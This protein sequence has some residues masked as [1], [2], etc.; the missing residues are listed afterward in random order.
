MRQRCHSGKGDAFTLIELL[1]VIAIIAVLAALLLPSLNR[2]KASA[3]AAAC[4]NNVRQLGLAL[5]MYVSDTGTFPPVA[6]QTA[7][8][9]SP[10][11]WYDFLLPS[12]I[13]RQLLLCPGT[14]HT[15]NTPPNEDWS[16]VDYGYNSEGTHRRLSSDPPLGL[17]EWQ[18][19]PIP[20]SRVLVPSDMLA[21]GEIWEFGQD[22]LFRSSVSVFPAAEYRHGKAFN[23]VFC[24]GHV[25]HSNPSSFPIVHFR[26]GFWWGFEP[27]EGRYKRFNN[28]N[29]P[30]PETWP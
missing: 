4:V 12:N 28:D 15:V 6:S 27:D 24:D 14:G 19:D 16:G 1:M 22:I 10:P 30:H 11:F 13:T 7:N 2:A 21:I 9:E 25:E 18:S 3:K 26:G 8:G 20:E 29:Q 23:A 17:G 5:Q